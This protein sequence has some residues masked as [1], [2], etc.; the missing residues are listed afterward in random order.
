MGLYKRDSVWWMSFTHNGKQIRRSTETDDRKLAIR[1]FDKLRGEIAEGKWFEKLPGKDYTFTEL[2]NKYLEEYSAVNKAK[3]SNLRDK[4]IAKHLRE[5]FGNIIL[6]DITPRQ[7]SEYKVKRRKDGVS[8]RTINYELT[9][10]GHAFNIAM[11]EWGWVENNPV[12][13]VQKERINNAIERWLTL[14]EEKKLLFSSPKW[15]QEIIVFAINTGLRE[16]EILDLKWSQIDLDRRTIIILEQKNRGVDTLPLNETA[17]NVLLDKNE[18]EHTATG[19][20]FTN[21]KKERIGTSH[22]IKSF[23]KAIRIS[24][25][26]KLRFH[27]LRHTFASR[28]VQGGADL[29]SVQKLGRWRNTSMVMRYAHHQPESLRSAIEVMDKVGGGIITN[30]SQSLKNRS[31]KPFLKIV[32]G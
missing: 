22:L 17:L 3:S 18:S 24:G 6:T 32:T 26:A 23:H 29:F 9:V 16:S 5:Y 13:K 7:I 15:L 14:D 21:P 20:V 11:R 10:I 4:G 27:D 25:I 31:G 1:I 28:L 12:N 8:P 2:I 30:L 19:L